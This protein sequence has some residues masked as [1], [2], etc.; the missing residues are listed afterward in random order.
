M[1]FD[2]KQLDAIH[3]F[4]FGTLDH[5]DSA[6]PPEK[7]EAWFRQNDA[8]DNAIVQQ[9]GPVLEEAGGQAFD[10]DALSRTQRVGLV[11]LFDQFPRNIFRASGEAFAHDREAR[12]VASHMMSRLDRYYMA[13]RSF[14]LLPLMHHEDVADQDLCV[15]LYATE[16]V[17]A[18]DR[19]KDSWRYA[20]DFATKHRDIIRK[21][22]RFPHRNA[23]LG[24]VS[25]PEEEA[26]LQQHGRGF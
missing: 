14:V 24:R 10:V 26:F 21:F 1:S 18:P 9:F 2:V 17:K 6:P 20:L 8:F 15:M 3:H 19:W 23:L 4:W 7:Q 5:H 13:E 25:T 12:A 11:I 22:G 16:T